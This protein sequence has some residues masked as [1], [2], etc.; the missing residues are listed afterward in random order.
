MHSVPRSSSGMKTVST[1]MPGPKRISHLRVPSLDV[2]AATTSGRSSE[3]LSF[4]SARNDFASVVIR[5]NPVAPWTYIPFHSWLAPHRRL[6]RL[7]A[8]GGE[9]A[10]QSLARQSDQR[11]LGPRRSCSQFKTK[12]GGSSRRPGPALIGVS[13]LFAAFGRFVE[14]GRDALERIGVGGQ[15]A[16]LGNALNR[17]LGGAAQGGDQLLL[18]VA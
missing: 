11:C 2:C 4:S 17:K 14:G 1:S 13:V 12:G 9:F 10:L 15:R 18:V 7:D 5:S 8:H 3:N 16:A 6:P